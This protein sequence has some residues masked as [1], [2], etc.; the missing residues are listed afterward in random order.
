MRRTTGRREVIDLGPTKPKRTLFG[1]DYIV[2]ANTLGKAVR[3]VGPGVYAISD[4]AKR[5][6][7]AK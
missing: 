1:Y 5:R 3:L 7:P 2:R 4:D 6:G